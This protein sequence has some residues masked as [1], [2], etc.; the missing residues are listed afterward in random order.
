VV[1]LPLASAHRR[2]LIVDGDASFTG[3][4]ERDFQSRGFTVATAAGAEEAI[5]AMATAPAELVVLD[6]YLPD[7]AALALLR[8]WK[9]QLPALV[10]ILVSGNASLPSVIDALNEGARRFFTKP[11][12][13]ET[14]LDELQDRQL[15]KQ[16]GLLAGNHSLG[17]AALHAEG[18]DRFFAVSP[19]LLCVAGFDGYFKML[20]PAWEKTL[21]YSVDELCARPQIELVHPD[22]RQK[23][24]DEG[25]EVC[26]GETVFRFKNRYRCK[27]G[28]YRWLEWN[29]M[30]NPASRLIY[31][32]ARDVTQRV[33]MEEGLRQSNQLLKGLVWS[34]EQ[35]L[36]ESAVK[37]ATLTEL[38]RTK[39]DVAA[40]IIHDL[41]NPLS[42]ILSNY[43]YVLEGFE[44]AADCLSA[45]Q[46]SRD[47]G[48]RM[49]RL[50]ANLADVARL[51]SGKIDVTTTEI[52]LAQLVQTVAEQRRV[53]A[54]SRDI[55]VVVLPAQ[56]SA[57]HIDADLVTR[58][59][60]NIFDN[61]LRYAPGGGCIEIELRNTGTDVEVRIGN[62][63]RAIP[64]AD[65]Q[66]VFEKYQQGS[67]D[68]GRMN[69]GLGLYFCRLATE[70][71]G[72][73]IWVEETERMPTVFV[74]RFPR[75]GGPVTQCGP[76][77]PAVDKPSPAS[78]ATAMAP[79]PL[80]ALDRE[81]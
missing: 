40:M 76:A 73:R 26:N 42:V 33:R 21:G 10:I 7:G 48:R 72:G 46:D 54:R 19:G 36:R 22:D 15:A 49:L 81:R 34:R 58:T 71:Q 67:S 69:L 59:V 56:E 65:R 4:L 50:L 9:A 12:S 8:L 17:L 74:L 57:I 35:L 28:S 47:A 1:E 75:K 32:S 68:G 14:L 38:G 24:A 79:A 5:A 43:E 70:A 29:A 31:A 64:L 18:V 55:E 30:P 3:A 13:A 78:A 66:R 39:D 44:G 27:D 45:L 23:A 61:A 2:I 37:N 62:S 6:L 53:I 60:E 16:A 51:E 63:G 80:R 20:N 77:A 11:V 41:K 52:S 25:L